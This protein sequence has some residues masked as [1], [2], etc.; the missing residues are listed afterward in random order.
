M[1]ISVCADGSKLPSRE[2]KLVGVQKRISKASTWVQILLPGN[3]WMDERAM[4]EWVKNVL[5]PLIKMGPENVFP[6]LVLDSYR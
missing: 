5:K 6:L 4:I 2:L 3:A 1:A